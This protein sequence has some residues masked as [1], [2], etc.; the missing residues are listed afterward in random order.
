MADEFYCFLDLDG[1]EGSATDSDYEDT[2][3]VHS[4]SWGV[5]NHGNFG[6]G[7]GGSKHRG[8]IHEINISKIMCK[9]SPTLM[10]YC[11]TGDHISEGTLSLCW[12]SG[13]TKKA[14]YEV[15]MKHI[16]LTSHQQAGSGGA[17]HPMESLSLQFVEMEST[18]TPQDNE[19]SAG[20]GVRFAWNLQKNEK[21]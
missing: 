19:G 10:Q 4:Y 16:R 20:G 3:P 1:I 2:I 17:Q 13:D 9:A 11:T 7:P 14:Y 8:Q 12:Q 15:K 5:T 18:Y 6:H 21:A